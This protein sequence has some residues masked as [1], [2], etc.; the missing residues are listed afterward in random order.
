MTPS[1]SIPSV[2][3]VRFLQNLT[4]HNSALQTVGRRGVPPNS[5]VVMHVLWLVDALVNAGRRRE[6]GAT[7]AP[8]GQ[9]GRIC[10]LN[11]GMHMDQS[12]KDQKKKRRGDGEGISAWECFARLSTRN[13]IDISERGRPDRLP[14]ESEMYARHM[15][16]RDNDLPI[17]GFTNH[18]PS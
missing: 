5:D 8:T 16:A 11:N 12:R 9:F 7:M 13:S 10:Q 14:S 1:L 3:T 18:V 4:G 15:A 2:C 17:R 6:G